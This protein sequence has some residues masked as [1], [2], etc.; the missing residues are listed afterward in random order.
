MKFDYSVHIFLFCSSRFMSPRSRSLMSTRLVDRRCF[1]L[2][3][4]PSPHSFSSIDRA[5]LTNMQITLNLVQQFLTKKEEEQVLTP[6]VDL[7]PCRS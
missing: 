4:P 6:C 1:P 2:F 5:S 3:A 7:F